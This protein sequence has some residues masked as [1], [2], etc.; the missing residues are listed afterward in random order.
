MKLWFDAHAPH[1]RAAIAAV[2]DAFA[3]QPHVPAAAATRAISGTIVCSNA[4]DL[5][6]DAMSRNIAAVQR[7]NGLQPSC[8]LGVDDVEGTAVAGTASAAT[9]ASSGFLDLEIEMETGTGKTYTYLRTALELA[10]R[11]G[12]RKFVIVVP[13][14]AIREGVLKTFALTQEHFLGLFPGLR[15][16]WFAYTARE[17]ERVVALC[18]SSMVEFMVVTIDAFNKATNI[19]RQP[20]DRFGGLAPIELL[21]AVRPVLIVDEPHRF[22]SARSRET[23]ARL[24]PLVALRYGATHR[25][26]HHLLYR[27]TPARAAEA[28][29]VKRVEVIT[30][31]VPQGSGSELLSAQIRQSIDL[32]IELQERVRARGVK[33]LSLFFVDRVRSFTDP[34]GVI[35][36]L[37]AEHFA[38]ARRASAA[39]RSLGP[40][41][42]CAAYFASRTRGK[43]SE[44]IDST[45]GDSQADAHAY[46][47]IMRDKERL[48][49]L[50][51]P[52][53]F[54]FSHSALREGWDNPN[55]FQICTL[56][57]SRSAIKKRQ[58]IGRGARLCVDQTGRRVHDAS[59]DVLRVIAN[60][61]YEDYV[62]D[63]ERDFADEGFVPAEVRLPQRATVQRAD[64]V[65]SDASHEASGEGPHDA[66]TIC[67]RAVELTHERL[68]ACVVPRSTRGA[69]LPNLVDRV[70]RAC[71]PAAALVPRTLILAALEE[72]DRRVPIVVAPTEV[73]EALGAAL[74]SIVSDAVDR[75]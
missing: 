35:R 60:E 33:V 19:L 57:R 18:R 25:T 47:L 31:Q 17:L 2:V 10:V 53:A 29:L 59:I 45:T 16:R 70:V 65:A 5:D 37:F 66:L 36:T 15:Y 30:P 49:A 52:V 44:A 27:L 48:L 26:R 63:L 11:Y 38:G 54:L 62:A 50:E 22:E 39:F 73:A 3:G 74:R 40:E 8:V 1:Q 61:S 20:H 67:R 43:H 68:G 64:A 51:E 12:L 69:A 46:R 72:I 34:D 21:A 14:L 56:A 13:S 7:I 4:R 42:V 24:Q 75:R 41:Q 58:E 32:H 23:L 6:V 9:T 55:V 71:G 28:G